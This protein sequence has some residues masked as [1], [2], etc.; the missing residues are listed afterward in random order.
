M[1]AH[2]NLLNNITIYSWGLKIK[3]RNIFPLVSICPPPPNSIS[4][5]GLS[6]KTDLYETWNAVCHANRKT[7]TMTESYNDLFMPNG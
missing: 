1:H 3:P 6:F 7:E 2:K 5:H 4:S